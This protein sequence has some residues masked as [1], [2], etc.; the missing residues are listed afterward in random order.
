[1]FIGNT[2]KTGRHDDHIHVGVMSSWS[3]VRGEIWPDAFGG[4][5][6]DGTTGS[7]NYLFA[8]GHVQNI[9]A[10]VLK[11]RVESGQ[12]ITVEF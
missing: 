9:A 8:D 5:S 10:S 6:P 7:A 11:E 2:N 1:M 4:G 3:G 12:D